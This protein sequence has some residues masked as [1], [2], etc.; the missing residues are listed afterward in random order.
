MGMLLNRQIKEP[1]KVLKKPTSGSKID[2]IKAYLTSKKIQFNES[3]KK[4][5]LLALVE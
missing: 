3:A 4:D 1:E 5:D 2:E